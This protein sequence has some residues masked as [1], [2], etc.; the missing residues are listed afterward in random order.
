[1]VEKWR[2]DLMNKAKSE[3]EIAIESEQ[4]DYEKKKAKIWRVYDLKLGAI[5]SLRE[6]PDMMFGSTAM[7]VRTS[8]HKLVHDISKALGVRLDRSA[9]RDGFSFKGTVDEVSIIVYGVDTVPH[10]RIVPHKKMVEVTEYET[11]CNGDEA[12]QET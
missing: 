2:T 11:V 4:R 9:D 7:F 5:A 3:A 10:C 8:D 12:K 6:R 1:M